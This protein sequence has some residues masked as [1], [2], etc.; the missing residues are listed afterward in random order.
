MASWEIVLD[1]GGD[2]IVF[3]LFAA[4]ALELFTTCR[5]V[6]HRTKRYNAVLHFANTRVHLQGPK[7]TIEE[8]ATISRQ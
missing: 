8:W 2:A 1:F 7:L 5:G 3:K 6:C 4:E